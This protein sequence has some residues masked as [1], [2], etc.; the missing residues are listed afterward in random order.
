MLDE[1]DPVRAP[2]G[3]LPCVVVVA[4]GLVVVGVELVGGGCVV[5][6]ACVV[7][8]GCVVCGT[9][10]D[11]S[12]PGTVVFGVVDDVVVVEVVVAAARAFAFSPF[13]RLVTF[14]AAAS[15]D[16]VMPP[17]KVAIVEG[18]RSLVLTALVSM[19]CGLNH[20]I[21]SGLPS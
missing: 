15:D 21:P 10:A 4:G 7:G 17:R 5:G 20:S 12:V 2:G 16:S 13:R 6:G 14:S 8:G 1:A 18:S 3:A 9:V 19:S 11:G